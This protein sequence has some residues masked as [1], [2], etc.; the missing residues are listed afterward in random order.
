MELRPAA[1]RASPLATLT[2]AALLCTLLVSWPGGPRGR[3]AALLTV[4]QADVGP[5]ARAPLV[6]GVP[7]C[8]AA[9]GAA[10]AI[11]GC[12]EV[13]EVCVDQQEVVMMGQEYI[14]DPTHPR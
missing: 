6:G 13:T 12:L 3:A 9:A 5:R 1:T 10:P 8:E 2:V 14:P 4:Q 7:S 11:D